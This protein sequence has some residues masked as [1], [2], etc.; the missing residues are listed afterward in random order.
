MLT[1]NF[2]YQMHTHLS[3]AM[4]TLLIY[5][6]NYITCHPCSCTTCIFSENIM[7][8]KGS[9]IYWFGWSVCIPR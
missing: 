5:Y 2:M 1:R 3:T 9:A 4:E 6:Y 7:F 8:E